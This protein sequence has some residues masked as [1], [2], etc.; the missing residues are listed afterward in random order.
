MVKQVVSIVYKEVKGLHQAA[1]VL[2]LF[3]FGSQLL[4]LLRDR[5]LA[6][7]F[8]AGSEL[9]LYYVA[10][11]IPDLLFVL[12]ASSLS[13]YVLIPFVTKAEKETE[14]QKNGGSALLSQ[15]FTLFLITYSVVAVVI[16]ITAPYFLPWFFPGVA[17]T[18]MLVLMTRILLLQPF[19]L[20]ISSLFGVVTQLGHRFVLYAISPLLYNIGIIF[21]IL[22]FYPLFGL[23]GLALGVILGALGHL[24]VQW[25]FVSKSDLKIQFDF[26][27]N[28]RQTLL[29]LI[30]S[31]PRALTLAMHQIVILILI[32]LASVMAV[33][34]ISVFQLA[35]NLQ[36]VPL[37][38]IGVSYSVAA[39]PVLAKM[40]A[41]RQHEKFT[42][43]VITTLRHI[44][45]WSLPVIA[46]II[47]IRAQL[48]R[49]VFGSGAFDWSDTRLTA[50]VLALLAI[51]LLAQAVILVVT[52]AFYAGGHTR[53][54]F[55]VTLVGS[56]LAIIVAYVFTIG[57]TAHSEIHSV[58]SSF[59]RLEGVGGSEVLAIALGYTLAMIGQSIVLTLLMGKLLNVP[60]G[61]M[62][63]S[64]IYAFCAATV[65]G[66]F[67]YT[68][69]N[70]VVVGIDQS[71]SIGVFIQGLVAGLFG[72]T[73]IILTYAYF[74]SPELH[75]I[76]K[77]FH[78]KIL[79]TDVVAVQEEIL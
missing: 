27:F 45:F 57:Y 62:W 66:L 67:A 63:R 22:V 59:M 51:S 26:R 12:F 16:A 46:L 18:E 9:D 10:F 76:Y 52:R 17:D 6:H 30:T 25:P 23:A 47:V 5:L 44:I 77:S 71:R 49:V 56:S 39:F 41:E 21:G 1:Y 32:G 78:R 14:G 15:I 64:L 54:P 7:Q 60:L 74:K 29:V 40:F 8:G 79:K 68:A 28:W 42:A 2:A 24:L 31:A 48:V 61:W 65:G 73:G 4:A 33:G 75:E 11:R 69:L 58:V 19:L 72:I 3:A 53:V 50:A 55:Y 34:S 36:S 70:F 35:F 37:A 20:G 13:V 43:Q 38:I